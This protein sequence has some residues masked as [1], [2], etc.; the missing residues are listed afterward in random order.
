MFGFAAAPFTTPLHFEFF[1][2]FGLFKRD[3]LRYNRFTAD[4]T[5]FR[6]QKTMKSLEEL[7]SMFLMAFVHSRRNAGR[8]HIVQDHEKGM[9]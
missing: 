3:Q 5:G 4:K 1:V 9:G 6:Y 8:L 2:N 7:S